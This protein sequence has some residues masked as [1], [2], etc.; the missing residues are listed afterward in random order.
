MQKLTQKEEEVMEFIWQLGNA[1]PKEVLALY[2]DPKPNINTVASS[3]QALERKGYLRHEPEGRGFRYFPI[4]AQE[5][6]G[7][8]KFKTFVSRYF[9]GSYK[10]LISAFVKDENVSRDE[11]IE[12][13]DDLEK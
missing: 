4:V 3:F 6:Y 9:S 13:L 7:K 12:L 5:D 11:L 2:E 1:A 10:Q 8:S